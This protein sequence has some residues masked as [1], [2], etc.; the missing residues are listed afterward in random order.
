MATDL[1]EPVGSGP[2]DVENRLLAAMLGAQELFAVY[3]GDRLG[4]YASLGVPRG[5]DVRASSPGGPGPTSGTRA[6]GSSTRPWRGT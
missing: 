2:D 6:S 1:F 5:L 4:W 3:A